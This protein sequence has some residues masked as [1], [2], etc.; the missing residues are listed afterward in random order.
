MEELEVSASDLADSDDRHR[1]LVDVTD[2][3]HRLT[4]LRGQVRSTQVSSKTTFKMP[5][6]SVIGQ[7]SSSV[8]ATWL[9]RLLTD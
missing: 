1:L 7:R 8:I 9:C 4:D 6:E 5:F 2:L 3:R